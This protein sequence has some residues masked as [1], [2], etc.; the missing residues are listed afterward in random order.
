MYSTFLSGFFLNFASCSLSSFLRSNNFFALLLTFFTSSSA[1]FCLT[2]GAAVNI[3]F[4][5]FGGSF[6][7]TS[8]W[9]GAYIGWTKLW[10]D[11]CFSLAL[12]LQPLCTCWHCRVFAIARMQIT[13]SFKT[14]FRNWIGAPCYVIPFFL[15]LATALHVIRVTR[16]EAWETL[17]NALLLS[18]LY[19]FI[20]ILIICQGVEGLNLPS[21]S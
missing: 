9:H 19:Y 2:G 1:S 11:S 20:H 5:F 10:T 3:F 12:C 6:S 18:I 15:A 7:R 17:T 4:S 14:K 16:G 13:G 21:I 8:F